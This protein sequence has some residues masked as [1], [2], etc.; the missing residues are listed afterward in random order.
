MFTTLRV[1]VRTRR[2][3]PGSRVPGPLHRLCLPKHPC[4]WRHED[5]TFPDFPRQIPRNGQFPS[6]W[7]RN[8]ALGPAGGH[9][10]HRRYVCGALPL[11]SGGLTPGPSPEA[12]PDEDGERAKARTRRRRYRRSVPTSASRIDGPVFFDVPGPTGQG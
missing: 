5:E 12:G 10:V 11:P 6:P 2:R 9:D 3:P 4:H 7:S 1:P 8:T